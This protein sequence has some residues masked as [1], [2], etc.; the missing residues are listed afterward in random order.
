MIRTIFGLDALAE[1]SALRHEVEITAIPSATIALIS[2][3][4]F[5]KFFGLSKRQFE[6]F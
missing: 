5:I 4:L 2:C 1:P 3:L 6:S